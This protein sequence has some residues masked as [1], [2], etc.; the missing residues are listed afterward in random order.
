VVSQQLGDHFHVFLCVH[1]GKSFKEPLS[2]LKKKIESFRIMF[3]GKSFTYMLV[4]C[5]GHKGMEMH[6]YRI[7]KNLD[8]GDSC[9]ISKKKNP[10]PTLDLKY[11]YVTGVQKDF[12]NVFL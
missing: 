7:K 8:E 3:S 10:A 1:I 11:L 6:V 12:Q 5:C 4:M 2:K 9:L